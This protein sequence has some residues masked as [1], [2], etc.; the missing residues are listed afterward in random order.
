MSLP[1]TIRAVSTGTALTELGSQDKPI[2]KPTLLET[3]VTERGG[4][5]LVKLNP[6]IHALGNITLFE[7]TAIPQQEIQQSRTRAQIPSQT[8]SPLKPAKLLG[9]SPLQILQ[10]G[11]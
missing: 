3:E 11:V 4:G 7:E 8:R 9:F 1:C 10:K 5:A 6:C 2:S